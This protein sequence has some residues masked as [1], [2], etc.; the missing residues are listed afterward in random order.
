MYGYDTECHREVIVE[1][2]WNSLGFW[3]DE[4]VLVVHHYPDW[5]PNPRE[6]YDHIASFQQ[7]ERDSIDLDDIGIGD[8]LV[9][10]GLLPSNGYC[11]TYWNDRWG[12]YYTEK[13]L[14]R[15]IRLWYPEIIW[16]GHLYKN[17]YVQGDIVNVYA[18]VTRDDMI[19]AG[20][21]ESDINSENAERI[22][23]AEFEEYS[24]WAIG[25]VYWAEYDGESVHGFI[26]S[27]FDKVLEDIKDSFG[28]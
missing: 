25:D 2:G 8:A 10:A 11:H 9:A 7:L 26:G 27:D 28:I 4:K 3:Q 20:F 16:H 22:A 18:I 14:A 21:S 15:H 13:I 1:S 6:D 17:G 19:K 24:A 23:R 5:T 12:D